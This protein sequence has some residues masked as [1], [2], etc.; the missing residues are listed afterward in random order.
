VREGGRTNLVMVISSG[1]CDSTA[2]FLYDNYV[3]EATS[4]P[5][6]EIEGIPVLAP[7]WIRKLYD[8]DSELTVD[9]IE[10][11]AED[12]LSLES[13]LGRRFVLRAPGNSGLG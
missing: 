10:S 1:C 13:D 11:P 6:G 7:E 4:E 2:P 3:P 9:A 5:V 12:S 8:G